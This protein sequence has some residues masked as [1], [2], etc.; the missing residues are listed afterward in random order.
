M[1]V[2]SNLKQ[3]RRFAPAPWPRDNSEK[4]E[5]SQ[6]KYEELKKWLDLE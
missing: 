4:S 6:R 2:E 5:E 3:E 1:S